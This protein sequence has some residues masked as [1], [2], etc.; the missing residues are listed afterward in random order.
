MDQIK[1]KRKKFR[2]LA[3]YLKTLQEIKSQARSRGF[4]SFQLSLSGGEPTINP[5]FFT[6]V[7]EIVDDSHNCNFQRLHMTT[8]LSR[9][10]KWLEEYANLVSKL[11]IATITASFHTEYA[12]REIFAEKVNMLQEYDIYVTINMV[13]VPDWF[14]RDYD[15][16]KYFH[17]NNINVT[18]KPQSDP[19]ASYIVNG[20]TDEQLKLLQTGFP[21]IDYAKEKQK[22]IREKRPKNKIFFESNPT[23]KKHPKSMQIEFIDEDGK[24]WY[25]DQAERFNAFGFNKFKTW[26]CCSGFN[27]IIILEPDG[28][29]RRSYGCIDEP[30]GNVTTGFKLFDKPRDCISPSC[31][32]SADSKIPKRKSGIKLPL[33]IG[34]KT[35]EL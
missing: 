32:S 12:D 19:S 33:F 11:H 21:Q 35:Y 14:D 2:D 29:I 8:N 7:K 3:V 31:V 34:D 9:D 18:L 5:H 23:Y 15:N 10:I 13:M 20:Y 26:E 25:M 27:S 24:Y 16:A 1:F 17:D 4:N 6:I 22:G 28:S 30:I